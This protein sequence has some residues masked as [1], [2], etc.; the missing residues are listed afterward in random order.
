MQVEESPHFRSGRSRSL[1]ILLAVSCFSSLPRSSYGFALAD[2]RNSFGRVLGDIP[3]TKRLMTPIAT[4]ETLEAESLTERIS[5]L[6]ML[7][8]E[9]QSEKAEDHHDGQEAKGQHQQEGKEE[10]ASEGEKESDSS[11]FDREAVRRASLLSK[12]ANRRKSSKGKATSVGS[13][14][15][16]SA[17]KAR[18]GSRRTGKLL[19]TVWKTAQGKS[20]EDKGNDSA[21]AK[22]ELKSPTSVIQQAID[23]LM[24]TYQSK[25]ASES[26][27]PRHQDAAFG[28]LGEPLERFESERRLDLG[29][30]IRLANVV[31]HLD[32]AHLRLSVFSDFSVAMHSEFCTRSCNAIAIRKERGASC[33]VA[34]APGSGIII[35]SVECSSHEFHGTRLGEQRPEASILYITEVAVHRSTRRQG[36]GCKLLEAVDRLAK[37]RDVES[38]YLH[39]DTTNEAAIAL[40][41][42]AGYQRVDTGEVFSEFTTSLNLHPGA[43]KGRDHFLFCKHL[44]PPTWLSPVRRKGGTVTPQKGLVGS[45]GFD[46]PA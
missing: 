19:D 29:R 4:E 45:F 3:R 9:V 11:G 42:K 12:G 30:N 41:E 25:R 5:T 28:V 22:L 15:I 7:D 38:L 23:E 6:R 40:Y 10:Y 33:I 1:G 35:G 44:K 31:D 27:Q 24:V 46:I 37:S 16:G 26:Q 8:D 18:Q 34:T 17:T 21:K 43:T 13:R 20:V 39:V 14:R 36:I 32:I 2:R